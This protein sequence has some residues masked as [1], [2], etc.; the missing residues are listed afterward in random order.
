MAMD[1]AARRAGLR[2]GMP[3]T[4]V[5]ALVAGL[6]EGCGACGRRG[7]SRQARSLGP[8]VLRTDRRR[9]TGC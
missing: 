1:E 5:Q 8:P 3:A 9:R 4:E 2:V 7:S 6:S